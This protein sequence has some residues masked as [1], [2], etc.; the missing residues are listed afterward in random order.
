MSGSD[1]R[2]P[3]ATPITQK[4]HLLSTKLYCPPASNN[5]VPRPRL[6]ALLDDGIRSGSKL[7][8]VAAPAGFG[9]TTLIA[10]WLQGHLDGGRRDQTAS[11]NPFRV[12]WVSLDDSD[13][14]AK[15]F[16]TYVIAALDG[17]QPGIGEQTLSLL[18]G[19]ND[20]PIESILVALINQL[21]A[22]PETL[23][24]VLDDY[25][26]I[27]NE[28]IHPVVGYLIEHLPPQM[29]LVIN[30]R[31]DPPFSLARLRG[32]GQLTEVRED[33][34]RFTAEEAST[35]L[36]QMMGLSLSPEHIDVL[37]TRTEGWITGLQ[38]AALS[39]QRRDPSEIQAF[40][41]AFTG[42]HTY[43][44]DYLAEEVFYDQSPETQEFLLLTSVL[45]RL[46][47]A[48]CDALTGGENGQATLE[49]LH[50]A[51]LF[52]VPL[53]NERQ[54]YRYHQLFTEFLRTQFNRIYPDR[55]PELHRRAALWY[56]AEGR[57]HRAIRHAL[58]AQDYELAADLLEEI[59]RPMWQSGEIRRVRNWLEALPRNIV[60]SRVELCLVFAWLLAI[61]NQ[62]TAVEPLLTAMQVHVQAC[63][64]TASL[65]GETKAIR[66][67]VA[68]KQ[69]R[70]VEAIGLL[71][72]ARDTLPISN[73][74]IHG[75][76]LYLLGMAHRQR[77]D[78]T[79][80][81][82]AYTAAID[83]N[84]KSGNALLC[85][86]SLSSLVGIQ[87]T[88]GQLRQ[89]I[90]TYEQALQFA[91]QQSKQSEWGRELLLSRTSN[92]YRG[93][94]TLLGEW[95]QLDEAVE[96]LKRAIRLAQESKEW[97]LLEQSQLALVRVKQAQGDI[98]SALEAMSQ[99]ERTA[100]KIEDPVFFTR[101][102]ARRAWAWLTMG[103]TEPAVKWAE[104]SGLHPSDIQQADWPNQVAD[105]EREYLTLA[106]VG[107]IQGR[108][109][110]LPLL[111]QLVE[112]SRNR[113]RK[114]HLLESLVLKAMAMYTQGQRT[115]ALEPLQQ[116]L[117]LAEPEGFVRLF[118]DKGP[119]VVSLLRDAGTQN[120]T[121][122]YV[123]R[124]IAAFPDTA[125]PNGMPEAMQVQNLISASIPLTTMDPLSPREFE[126]LYLIAAGL[127]NREISEELV[128][129]E[130]TVKGH[131]HKIYRKLD[132]HSRTQAVAKAR[133]YR[134]I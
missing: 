45:N 11:V 94:G 117:E 95:N 29:H 46:H 100:L 70:N 3:T 47:G 111:D 62:L 123:A 16:W 72:Q 18:R 68:T 66:A 78:Y 22:L 98:D 112:S 90:R 9:K 91:T 33:D 77:E 74:H 52:I 80:A 97:W 92:L 86:N 64:N 122:D 61:D 102:K 65:E 1:L 25:H 14:D 127:S 124:L 79:A 93:M 21:A 75:I 84:L 57:G 49:A 34:L 71:H 6:H 126:V 96:H 54:W 28:D 106:W 26:L 35:F 59:A 133:E 105:K 130:G 104:A 87:V 134:L 63:E 38:L 60:Q 23:V 113:E 17:L 8:L 58:K 10:D 20:V 125:I 131:V 109:E 30:S 51:N 24:L 82:T 69:H 118:V 15:M 120:I 55:A 37:G 101:F 39:V 53:D 31:S 115:E 88:Q 110:V 36:N 2:I 114:W 81:V 40:V 27:E 5:L 119:V 48:L 132:A 7:I 85:L 42:Q 107:I 89:A 76:V 4:Y 108:A 32:Y 116:A 56:K 128:I 19:T 73:E 103:D 13:N 12:A 41:D 83:V 44:I 129:T 99:A 121:P 50:Q 67:Y 43:I